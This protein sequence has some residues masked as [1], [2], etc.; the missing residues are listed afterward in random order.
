MVPSHTNPTMHQ[1]L[2]VLQALVPS[3]IIH[4]TPA[5]CEARGHDGT[6]ACSDADERVTITTKN[7]R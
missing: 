5:M 7:I 2:G 6:D 4:R 1:I 3:I